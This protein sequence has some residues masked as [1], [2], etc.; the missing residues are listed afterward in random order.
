MFMK[1]STLILGVGALILIVA[2]VL[3]FA[4]APNGDDE[5]DAPTPL[6]GPGPHTPAQICA[7]ST[8]VADPD[9][10]QFSE[11]DSVLQAGVDYQAIFCTDIGSI[12]FELFEAETPITVNSFVFLAGRGFYNNN[13]FHRVIADFMAQGGDPVGN[14][15]GTGGPGYLF[16]DE[17]VESLTFDEPGKLAMANAGPATN[18]SQFFI[19]TAPTPNLQNAHTIFGQVIVGQDVVNRIQLR[20]P[21]DTGAPATTLEAVVIITDPASVTTN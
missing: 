3:L 20:D 10:R 5:D 11:P 17:F 15:I 21:R 7:A 2:A 9:V 4:L 12:Y 1:N 6:V 13:I 8:P 18:G 19:T 14:P 16:Q